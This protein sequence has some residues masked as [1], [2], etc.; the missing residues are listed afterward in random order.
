MKS[1][2]Y[3]PKVFEKQ[4]VNFILKALKSLTLIKFS[5]IC[6]TF[7]RNYCFSEQICLKNNLFFDK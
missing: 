6:K 5:I 2:N 7:D 4:K 1:C 3:L